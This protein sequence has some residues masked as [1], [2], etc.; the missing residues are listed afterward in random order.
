MDF[1]INVHGIKCGGNDAKNF[2]EKLRKAMKEA[3]PGDFW[4]SNRIIVSV[5][6]DDSI[7]LVKNSSEFFTTLAACYI[8][9]N[10]KRETSL[11]IIRGVLKR[12]FRY[13]GTEHLNDDCPL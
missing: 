11:D 7:D 2:L 10:E 6:G 9:S 3:L 8:N 12:D 13:M 1:R 4:N 5:V